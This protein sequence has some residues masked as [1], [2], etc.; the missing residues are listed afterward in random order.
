[1]GGGKM[2]IKT[3]K[4]G[5]IINLNQ[6]EIQLSNA[7]D[8]KDK[9]YQH[10]S[11]IKLTTKIIK[12]IGMQSI[13]NKANIS[14]ARKNGYTSI[15]ILPTK[16]SFSTFALKAE[17]EK[18]LLTLSEQL[19]KNNCSKLCISSVY[20]YDENFYLTITPITKSKKL[21]IISKEFC[22]NIIKDIKDILLIQKNGVEIC[23]IDAIEKLGEAIS[24]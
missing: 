15:L 8:N 13:G 14:I 12:K 6:N 10:F 3:I 24:K 17:N 19:Y 22:L 23:S 2:I 7:L 4:N 1:M 5:Y 16:E 9:K 20:I 11:L 18:E 21:I